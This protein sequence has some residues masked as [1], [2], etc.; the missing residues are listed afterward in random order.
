MG[1]GVA[2]ATL[3][4]G[5]M[6]GAHAAT[7]LSDDFEDGNASGWSTNGGSWSVATDGSRVYRQGGTSSDARAVTGTASWTDYAVQARVKPTAFNGSNRFA[8]VLARVQ[9]STSY[10]YLALRSN[11]TVE[12]KRLDGGSSATLDTASVAVAAG[13]WY[14]LKLEVSGST[15]RGYVNGALLTEATDTRWSS[16]RIGVATFY[17]SAN[18]DDVQVTTGGSPDPSGSVSTTPTEEPPPGPNVAD[19]WASVN[20]WGQNGTSGGAG[21]PTVTVSTAAAFT[22]AIAR[23]GPLVV[24]VQGTITLPGPMHDVSSD[25]T[26]IG[27]GSGATI[28]GGGLNIGLPIDNA[29]TAPP[30]NAV[31]NVIIRNLRFSGWPDD[32]INVQMFSHHIWIDHNTWTTGSDGG[33]DIKRG[34]SYVTV[35]YNHADGTDKNMLLGHDD[36]NA[37]QDVGR[38]KVS[39][40]H[41]WFD[42]TRQR[43]PRVR[44]GDQVHVYNNHYNDTGDYGIASTEDAGVIVEGN[45]FENVDD[46]YHLGEASSGP[47]RIVAR[48]N[49]FVN[50]GA[51]QAGGSVTPVPYAYTLLPCAR[52]KAAVT[53]QAGAGRIGVPDPDP[54]TPTPDPT[55]PDPQPAPGLVGW[56]TQNGGT[57]GGAGGQTVTVSDGQT[58][59]D[60]LES[61][62]PLIIRV[63][64]TLTMPDKMNDVRSNKTVLGESGAVLDNGLNISGARNVIVRNLTFRGWDDDAINVQ[65][66]T[67][68]WLDH[69][70][71]DGGYDG[72]LDIKR[73]SDFVTVSWNRVQNHTKSM[74]LGHDDGHTADR[75]KLRVT[76]H[77]NWFDGSKERHPRVRFGD[78]VHVFNNYYNGADYGVASTMGAGVLVE[79]NYFEN[80]TRPTAVGYAESGPGDLVQRDNVFV[81]SG[82]PESAGDVAAIPYEYTRDAASGVKASVT[83]GAG[84]GRITV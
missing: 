61:S 14:T 44:F 55:D 79:S 33:V 51:G 18:F 40:H 62:S 26:I 25:K 69:N 7:L 43:N 27:L 1:A 34:S 65:G 68:V 3:L 13:T 23:P 56:A 30:A 47:G 48:D 6:T 10:Y 38:L 36:N 15:L 42:A 45:S 20:A 57:T 73:E 35:S 29:V 11:N 50:S 8:A 84:A 74:L 83:A 2:A 59:A 17:T 46:P 52:V 49:C 60:A 76:Y 58:L 22:E 12:L 66:S 19:G 9:S 82:A 16:G 63:R 39:Y 53:T 80:V 41:N 37:A 70:T 28:T 77:H 78:P 31:N 64:G 75:G 21:G 5:M 71:F 4:L 67:N 54:T 72:A 24:Q 32:A 81:G